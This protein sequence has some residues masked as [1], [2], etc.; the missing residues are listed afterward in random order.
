MAT[1]TQRKNKNGTKVWRAIIRLKGYPTVCDHFD[2]KQEA[3]DWANETEWQIKL[4]RYKFGKEDQKKTLSDLI[5]RYFSDG[6]LDHHKSPKD[7][8]R[9][10]EYFRSSLGSY[11]LTYLTPELLLSERKKL[12]ETPTYRG[13]KRNPATVNRYMSSLSGAL[14]YAC[15]NLRWIDENPCSNHKTKPCS[16]HGRKTEP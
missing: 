6:V 2:R 4:G 10:L 8:K 16:F 15:R 1:I 11:A 3:Q 7:A 9:H 12:Q 5:D 14:C 13:E